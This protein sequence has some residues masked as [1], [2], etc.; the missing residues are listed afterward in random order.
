MVEEGQPEQ[1]KDGSESEQQSTIAP[2]PQ[3]QAKVK[4]RK[5]IVA[6]T[7][8]S[9]AAPPN[10]QPSGLETVV[11]ES[12]G[13]ALEGD[14]GP[15]SITNYN[16]DTNTITFSYQG[17]S[18]TAVI[19][20]GTIS[21]VSGVE[22][23]PADSL[24]LALSFATYLKSR[25]VS[26]YD[27]LTEK[28]QAY[29]KKA[30]E[31][32]QQLAAAK[33][34]RASSETQLNAYKPIGT[35]NDFM[36]AL[37]ELQKADADLETAREAIE[38]QKT[39]YELQIAAAKVTEE[40]L[41]EELNSM[42]GKCDDLQNLL[43]GF[44][45]ADAIK[46]K[47]ELAKTAEEFAEA[48]Y[49]APGDVIIALGEVGVRLG[50]A[51]ARVADLEEE[52]KAY[53]AINPDPSVLQATSTEAH[54]LKARSERELAKT[55][56]ALQAYEQTGLSAGAVLE[57]MADKE[58]LAGKLAKSEK[59]REGLQGELAAAQQEIANHKAAPVKRKVEVTF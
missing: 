59:T 45:G 31:L 26:A 42:R 7:P 41:K 10:T 51:S 32:E 8:D 22:L 38:T 2:E 54:A 52:L 33:A 36:R 5:V 55:K 44:G 34:A 35:P 15:L 58:S 48:G 24:Q 3:P 30:E 37:D 47:S 46:Q 40:N 50:T 12:S 23:R 1:K 18:A 43:A 39:A 4:R 49:K 19:N 21:E 56:E 20:K 53:H 28:G 9:S 6:R 27:Q 17:Q 11:L 29:Q 25:M 14:S 57:V 13:Q 16:L